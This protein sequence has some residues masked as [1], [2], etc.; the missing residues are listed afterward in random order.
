M[1]QAGT[2]PVKLQT[3]LS[4]AAIENEA[5]L[6]AI[7]HTDTGIAEIPV[8]GL[9][10]D[11]RR[12]NEGDV[13]VALRGTKV[14]GRQ[15][16]PE[17]I[18]AGACAVLTE[19]D[20]SKIQLTRTM[21]CPVVA[22]SHLAHRLSAL[23][24]CFYK[25][26][27]RRMRVKGV[28][29]TNGKTTCSHLLAQFYS[30]LGVGGATLGTLG[31]G[32]ATDKALTETGLTTPDAIETQRILA[33]LLERGA[34]V[35]AMEVSSHSLDQGRVAGIEFDTAVFTNL[36]RDHLDYH[37]DMENYARAKRA[38]FEM[39]GLQRAVINI[40]DPVG[41]KIHGQIR[42]PQRCS[43]AVTRS[44][45]DVGVKDVRYTDSG[46]QA[47]VVSPWGE[48]QLR[49]CLL[50]VFNLS[51]LLAVIATVCAQGCGV[52]DFE[53]V[54]QL[55]ARLQPVSGRMDRLLSPSDI[56]VVIDYAH[57]PDALQQSLV[58][59]QKHLQ[60]QRHRGKLWCVFGCGGDRDRG[61]RPLMGEIA[62]KY[63]DTL[64]VTSDNPRCEE[65]GRIIEDIL[66]GI[67]HPTGIDIEVDRA[68]A[69]AGAIAMAAPGDCLLIAGKGHEN[70][71]QVGNQRLTFCDKE[72]AL[73]ALEIRAGEKA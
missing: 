27:A 58:A 17:A 14:D 10:L 70:Y 63:A 5:V 72:Q 4:G 40:D 32:L 62:E 49:S 52:N 36:S 7:M 59:L 6:N 61:K 51:N 34:G 25:W 38:L 57:T 68:E 13:F 64:V 33:C 50:G 37:G 65:P 15:F 23:A 8:S 28:T 29:G 24:G 26:P 31:Y 12:V 11:S 54:L 42:L 47:L 9:S 19:A 41:E 3:L 21:G 69:I 44:D 22:I 16:I 20:D 18:A 55:A 45:A 46:I 30:H 73:R 71:Q 53:N 67:K 1:M 35:V 56:T 60:G 48:G 2:P 39:P 43:Y 66:T